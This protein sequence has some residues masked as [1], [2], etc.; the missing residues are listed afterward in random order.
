MTTRLCRTCGTEVQ[1]AGG[2]CLLGHSLREAPESG[3]LSALRAEVDRAFEE[4]QMVVDQSHG[5]PASAN[6][7]LLPPPPPP[8]S[9][10]FARLQIEQSVTDS[11]PM[12]GFAPAPRMD[13][14]PERR[15]IFERLLGSQR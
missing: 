6:E 15:K 13:W 12:E 11:D 9:D 4:A 5:A 8:R 1:D 10:L 2:Y 7:V 3:S 14:G